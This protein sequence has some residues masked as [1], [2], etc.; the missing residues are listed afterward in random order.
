MPRDYLIVK[1]D[2][3]NNVIA[4]F[5]QVWSS[6]KVD[7][8]ASQALWDSRAE[9]FQRYKS[10]DRVNQIVG[11][12]VSRQAL[13]ESGEVLDIGCGAGRYSMEFAQKAKKVTGLDISPKMI[14][15]AK[16][17]A[18]EQALSNTEF[19]VLS[20]EE[21]D[22]EAL[23]WKKKFNLAAA[24]MTPAISS[25][26]CLDK[27]IAA[28]QGYCIMSGH[29]DKREKVMDELEKTVLGRDPVPFD[30]GMNIYC[31]F[32]VLWQY[33]IYPELTYYD[34]KRDNLR[35]VEEAFNYYCAQL[36]RKYKLD[37][38]EKLSVKEYL[39]KIA[40]KGQV[41]DLFESRTAWLF[42]ENK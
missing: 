7:L 42:W 10:N 36:E 37:A 31:S 39:T 30:Y 4:F 29:L 6:R 21:A 41:E 9:E 27:M 26:E 1:E 20:W 33:G 2:F 22:V 25:R 5:D 15:F 38:E 40:H 28:S 14:D 19:R 13:N 17:N 16:K 24:I 23:G 18:L 12:L 8:D 34:M 35:P 32:N 11:F 3:M